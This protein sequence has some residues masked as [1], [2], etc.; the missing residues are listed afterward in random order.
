LLGHDD[1]RAMNLL[2][3]AAS[4]YEVY[5][6]IDLET[7]RDIVNEPV[8]KGLSGA[9]VRTGGVLSGPVPL[10][11]RLAYA[12][13][14][15]WKFRRAAAWSSIAGSLLTRFGWIQAGHASAKDH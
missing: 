5:E 7:R 12:I 14:G 1:S 6:G 9:I 8:H 2:G 13:T 10:G 3:I 11:L 15:N 4:A